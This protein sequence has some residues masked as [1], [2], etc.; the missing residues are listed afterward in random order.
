MK[1]D[2]SS[3]VCKR[4][5][6]SL[7]EIMI[8]TGLMGGLSLVLLSI[9]GE[10]IKIEQRA[11]MSGMMATYRNGLSRQLGDS[12]ACMNTFGGR[13][14]QLDPIP[15]PPLSPPFP[16][17]VVRDKDN[18][19][20]FYKAGVN[21]KPDN[22]FTITSMNFGFHTPANP[23]AGDEYWSNSIFTMNITLNPDGIPGFKGNRQR[24]IRVPLVLRVRKTGSVYTL[25]SCSSSLE[26]L[27]AYT[28]EE[29]CRFFGAEYES[30]NERCL[31]ASYGTTPLCTSTGN[32]VS[33][34]TAPVGSPA[35]PE[36]Y[37]IF[38]S[39]EAIRDYV[40]DEF[41]RLAREYPFRCETHTSNILRY[42]PDSSLAD[43]GRFERCVPNT[44]WV[45]RTDTELTPPQSNSHNCVAAMA[46][47]EDLNPPNQV[48]YSS[49]T[50]CPDGYDLMMRMGYYY[51]GS[52]SELGS[53]DITVMLSSFGGY[54]KRTD[55]KVVDDNMLR[56][57][58][59][60]LI[61]L[62][63]QYGGSSTSPPTTLVGPN[64][65]QLPGIFAQVAHSGITDHEDRYLHSVPLLCCR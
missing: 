60:G 62:R 14:I 43:G 33:A 48:I 34:W 3:I 52:I 46:R 22:A 13:G 41:P 65:F 10:Q 26:P 8:A 28:L 45:S 19:E 27:P 25:L 51:H 32:C 4:S 36:S 54:S 50:F 30:I 49:S 37:S 42:V 16:I 31:L 47:V 9:T 55:R 17:P 38:V 24:K 12:Q 6:L 56:P 53:D 29:V 15:T 7:L 39:L 21:L 61:T 1:A 11:V 64:P 57:D 40:V 63:S 2:I 20:T 35:T 18:D 59:P 5:G 58:Y 23:I 44:G